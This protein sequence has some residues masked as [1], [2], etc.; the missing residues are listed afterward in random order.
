M[1]A[2][3][4][5]D[6]SNKNNSIKVNFLAKQYNTFIHELDMYYINNEG[7]ETAYDLRDYFIQFYIKSK[8]GS[9][10]KSIGTISYIDNTLRIYI[11]KEELDFSGN[12]LYELVFT[13]TSTGVSQTV[14][15]GSFDVQQSVIDLFKDLEYELSIMFSTIYSFVKQLLIK[16]EQ[17]ISFRSIYEF[18]RSTPYKSII[19]LLSY[20]SYTKSMLLTQ[21]LNIVISSIYEYIKL[22]SFKENKIIN[23]IGNYIYTK[24]VVIK[25]NYIISLISSYIYSKLVFLTKGYVISFISSYIYY[26]LIRDDVFV[27]LESSY[28]YTK[29]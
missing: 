10:V 2:G 9:V 8:Y 24:L 21:K 13:E 20:Y 6:N 14:L 17:T 26:T 7:Y 5:S 1:I 11:S 23:I 19:N 28:T 25:S 15:E 12:Y 22:E 16:Q 29:A 4:G 3:T 27:S 18:I